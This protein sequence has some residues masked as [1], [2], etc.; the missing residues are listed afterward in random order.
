MVAIAGGNLPAATDPDGDVVTFSKVSDP[1]HGTV[2]VGAAGQYTYTPAANWSG[3]DAFTFRVADTRGG[4]N[5]YSATVT[6]QAVLDE[7]TGTPSGDT[8]VDT[9]GDARLFGLSGND[10][11][12]GGSGNDALDGGSGTD[13]AVYAGAA[14]GYRVA[15][16]GT[17]WTVT[18]KDGG[19]GTDTLV[20]V[21]RLDFTDRDFELVA[22][23]R[24]GVP[25]YGASDALLFDPVYYTLGNAQVV[26]ALTLDTAWAHYAA[27]GAAA[28]HA[29]NAWFDAGWYE[30]RWPDLAPL[31]LDA[32]TLFRHFNLFGVWEG[33]APGPQF[34]SFDGTRYLA[35]NPDVAAY[36]DANVGDFLGSRSNGAIAH[37]I[38]YGASEGRSAFTGSGELIRTGYEFDLGG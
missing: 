16:T 25:A 6:V 18:D 29:P 34:A 4:A 9:S 2:T 19:D 33:R 8:L 23:A 1:Q 22:P 26:P 12:Q 32:A 17:G 20:A 24:I 13:T 38:L 27:T 21:E 7:L 30:N 10:R 28:G 15:R 31:G 11:L 37:Y 3:S 35:S 5:T 14:S 36:V